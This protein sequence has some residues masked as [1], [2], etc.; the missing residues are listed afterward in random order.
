[1]HTVNDAADVLA[2]PVGLAD[3]GQMGIEF[4]IRIGVRGFWIT[5][6]VERDAINIIVL[7]NLATDAGDIVRSLW[8][9]WYHEHLASLGSLDQFGVLPDERFLPVFHLPF[10]GADG[11]ADQPGMQFH[12]T[13]VTLF[14]AEGQGVVAWIHARRA[15]EGEFPR[16]N[17]GR[18]EQGS[19]DAGLEDDSVDIRLLVIVED[20]DEF[21]LLALTAGWVSGVD[22]GPV[23]SSD[24]GE[25]YGSR[26]SQR[27]IPS[28]FWLGGMDVRIEIEGGERL[29]PKYCRYEAQKCPDKACFI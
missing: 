15:R 13:L 26:F 17:L 29:S 22:A 8:F 5:D 27:M 19:S 14:D 25:P 12:A 6:I 16:L 28:P 10:L 20:V 1:M 7:Y 2:S 11:D 9:A 24:G 23:E 21:L 18:V 3:G 4:V